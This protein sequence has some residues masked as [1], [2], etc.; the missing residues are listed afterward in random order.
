MKKLQSNFFCVGLVLLFTLPLRADVIKTSDGSTLVG[1][2]EEI[3]GGK[4]VILTDIAGRLEIDMTKVTAIATENAVNVAVRSG[5]TVVGVVDIG[6]E[7]H[8]SVVH[9]KLGDIPVAA[10]SVTQLWPKGADSPDVLAIRAE[11]EQQIEAAKPKWTATLEGGL[12]RKE[13]NTD[14]LEGHGSFRVDRKTSDD[15]LQF[16]LQGKYHEDTNKRTQN[17]Y[18]GGIRYENQMTE[19][20]YWYTRTELEFDEFEDLDLR[21]TAAAGF[22]YYWLK[23]PDHELKTSIGLGYRHEA[24][25]TGRSNDD[26]M[27]DLGLGYRRD[28]GDK[29][30]FTHRLVYSPDF[31]EFDNYRVQA[32]TA[33]LIPFK[34]DSLAWKL[35]I[36][37]EYNSRPVGSNERLDNTY[38]TSIVLRIR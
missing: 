8:G 2:I 4:L 38:Y 27:L 37:N 5:D 35:G 31:L 22:G 12:T 20:V 36:R 10:S 17:E 18:L 14:T 9:S 28:I 7:G 26:P 19:R 13:G 16:Y 11:A 15:L 25:D 34:D 6:A 23:D 3:S 24:Y 32:D 29:A 30:Q 33:L 1:T 21:A